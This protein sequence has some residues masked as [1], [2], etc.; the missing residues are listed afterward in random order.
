MSKKDA[1][2][3]CSRPTGFF[4]YFGWE[5]SQSYMFFFYPLAYYV[6]LSMIKEA[7]ID[8]DGEINYEEFVRMMFK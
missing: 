1:H 7:D 6:F 5:V 8:G 2:N 3:Y 4:E